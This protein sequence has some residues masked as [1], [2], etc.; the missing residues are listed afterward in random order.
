MITY[1]INLCIGRD[2]TD[3]RPTIK[4]HDTGVNFL[5]RLFEYKEGK[6]RD[7]YRR[8]ALPKGATAV[9]KIAKP[10]NTFC[11]FDGKIEGASDVLF[12]PP[13]QAFTVEGEASAEVAIFNT[14]GKR[15]T[16]ATFTIEVAPEALCG[17]D[18]ESENYVDVFAEEMKKVQEAA[19]DA[20]KAADRAESAASHPPII[21]ENG[22]WYLW[23][24]EKY[25]DSGNPSRGEDGKDGEDGTGGNIA[26]SEIG[27]ATTWSSQKI[28]KEI[29][30]IP[31]NIEW[32]LGSV[33][34]NKG[35]DVDSTSRIRTGYIDIYHPYLFVSLDNSTKIYAHFFADNLPTTVANDANYIA[36]SGG[37]L[38]TSFILSDIVPEGARYVRFVVGLKDDKSITDVA[39]VPKP[40]IYAMLGGVTDP[41]SD[42]QPDVPENIGVLNAILN[43]KQLAEVK[44]SIKENLPVNDK[45]FNG[46]SYLPKGTTQTGLPY[47]SSR[48]EAG[49]VPNFVS[50]HTFMTALQNPNSYLYTVNLGAQGNENGNTY[51]GAVCSTSCGYALGITPNYST[52]QWGDIPNMERLEWQSVYALKLGDT[53]C[54]KGHVV[55]VTNITRNKRGRIGK[56]TITEAIAPVVKSTEYT[57]EQLEAKYPYADYV[58]Y[59]YNKI[60]EV[61]HIQSPFVAVEDEMPQEVVYNTAIIPRKGDKSNWLNGVPVEIDILEK[62]DYTNVEIYKDG[63]LYK[64]ASI[65][66][67]STDMPLSGIEWGRGAYS[68][69]D[70]KRY[71]TAI[72]RISSLSLIPSKDLVINSPGSLK[73]SVAFYNADATFQSHTGWRTNEATIKVAELAPQDAVFCGITIAYTNDAEVTDIPALSSL[74]SVQLVSDDN[75]MPVM[76]SIGGLSSAN[77]NE[78]TNSNRIRSGFIPMSSWGVTCGATIRYVEYYYD[79]DKNFISST[80]WKTSTDNIASVAPAG[81]AF[82]R[83]LIKPLKEDGSDYTDNETYY[84]NNQ[85]RVSVDALKFNMYSVNIVDSDIITLAGI[86]YGSYKARLT[87]DVKNSEWCYWMV[88]DAV[89]TAV[90]TGNTGEVRV[91]FSASNATP[92]FVSWSDGGHNGTVHISVLSDDETKDKSAVCSYQ[93]GNYKVRVAFQTE[94]GIIHSALSSAITV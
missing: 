12:T 5:V 35:I 69:S 78:M 22:N 24:G 45:S 50:M 8:Y 13:P 86:P 32:K 1:D 94:Y 53:I 30:N 44:Y 15:I 37:W 76:F 74:I 10:D 49:F 62:D 79:K 36:N 23:N 18:E 60:N 28:V 11:L 14:S 4:C 26:D 90:P 80:S 81:S 57:P 64:T 91:D 71:A 68:S 46:V 19:E 41:Y 31:L 88:V 21:G 52:H 56:V 38:E 40:N 61:K 6:W 20:E 54:G 73:I 65:S 75:R 58:Y 92:L 67:E 63:A 89:S 27:K 2:S 59:R 43:F 83:F 87:G 3:A 82:V 55:M 84:L 93:A 47:S 66:G 70:G 85:A 17:C 39:E 25:E 16:S 51:Y 7:E 33:S 29:F 72:N 9:V 42:Y 34:S 77:G 48:P